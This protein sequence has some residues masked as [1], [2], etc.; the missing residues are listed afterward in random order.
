MSCRLLFR[1]RLTQNGQERVPSWVCHTARWPSSSKSFDCPIGEIDSF[2]S[3]TNN[4][5]HFGQATLFE[6]VSR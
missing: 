2:K 6:E 5:Q 3:E 1:R 4:K